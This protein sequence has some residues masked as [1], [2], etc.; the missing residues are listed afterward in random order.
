MEAVVSGGGVA[1]LDAHTHICDLSFYSPCLHLSALRDISHCTPSPADLQAAFLETSAA[2]WDALGCSEPE[3]HS[4]Q[5]VSLRLHPGSLIH[6][7]MA[8]LGPRHQNSSTSA[9]WEEN[10][11]WLLPCAEPN[12]CP[13]GWETSPAGQ[14]EPVCSAGS[15]ADA[16]RRTDSCSLSLG[17]DN[18]EMAQT[19]R[20]QAEVSGSRPGPCPPSTSDFLPPHS[21]DLHSYSTNTKEQISRHVTY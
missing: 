6:A 3:D 19:H 7:G 9:C 5:L 21:A 4:L 15:R 2:L 12:T 20:G 16:G 8:V 1:G 18:T 14:T 17:A 10:Y 13:V 11:S